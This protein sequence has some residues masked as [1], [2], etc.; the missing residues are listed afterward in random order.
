[1]QKTGN[2]QVINHEEVG[3]RIKELRVSHDLS[4]KDFAHRLNMSQ[5]HLSRVEKGAIISAA[6][7]DLIAE[8]FNTTKEYLLY[9][10]KAKPLGVTSSAAPVPKRSL[11]EFSGFTLDQTDSIASSNK[12]IKKI[13]QACNYEYS[14]TVNE[15]R[16]IDSILHTDDQLY[17]TTSYTFSISIECIPSGYEWVA[18]EVKRSE[19][20]LEKLEDPHTEIEFRKRLEKMGRKYNPRQTAKD[21]CLFVPYAFRMFS[22]YDFMDTEYGRVGDIYRY[23]EAKEIALYS[24]LPIP[25]DCGDP[26]V[27]KLSPDRNVYLSDGTI[28]R[29]AEFERFKQLIRSGVGG[30]SLSPSPV[31]AI[32][33]DWV[34]SGSGVVYK[35]RTY[36]LGSLGCARIT[37]DEHEYGDSE[38]QFIIDD[39]RISAS[40]FIDMLSTYEGWKMSFKFESN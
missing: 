29:E 6:L 37:V 12:Q 5:G 19:S 23:R 7:C 9:G 4:Q 22:P 10:V 34:S 8:K 18:T 1:M 15:M 14:F 36:S 26:I 33:G 28:D 24:G 11:D 39:K 30:K 13:L 16:D 21:T 20:N 3:K 2:A 25:K 27:D 38:V 17:P 31:R 40:Q 32:E 35:G